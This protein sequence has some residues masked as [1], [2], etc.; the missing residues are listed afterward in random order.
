MPFLLAPAFDDTVLEVVY[1]AQPSEEDVASYGERVKAAIKRMKRPWGCLVDQRALVVVRPDLV[2]KL[3]ELNAFAQRHGMHCSAR[4]VASKVAEL[5]AA[6]IAREGT[7]H[8]PVRTFA[9]RTV[10]LSWVRGQLALA[11]TR[12]T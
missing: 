12:A 3:S 9:D 7:L 5:Q 2:E 6:R 10:A 8:V 4:I 11:G 1:P